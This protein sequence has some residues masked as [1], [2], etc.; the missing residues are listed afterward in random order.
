MSLLSSFVHPVASRKGRFALWLWVAICLITW[1]ATAKY[2]YSWPSMIVTVGCFLAT[3]GAVTLLTR[4]VYFALTLSTTVLLFLTLLSKVKEF[5]WWEKLLFPDFK[6]FLDTSNMGVVLEFPWVF[7]LFLLLVALL[8]VLTVQ[9][10]RYSGKTTGSRWMSLGCTIVGCA[11]VY[12]MYQDYQPT[13]QAKLANRVSN[14]PTNLVMTST[15]HYQDP[16]E[17]MTETSSAFLTA[18]K[19]LTPSALHEAAQKQPLPDIVVLLQ[20]S[21]F[22]PQYYTDIVGDLPPLKMFEPA[23]REQEGLLRV[24]TYGGS[25]WRSEFSVMSGLSSSDFGA[26]AV[27]INYTSVEYVRHG[28]FTELRRYGYETYVLTPFNPRSYNCDV[29]YKAMGV[30][31]IRQPQD[32]GYPAPK[33]KNLWRIPTADM[34]EAVKKLLETEPHD[35][36]RIVFAMTMYEH[37]PYERMMPTDYPVE[38]K[39]G[40]PKQEY[41]NY[42]GKLKAADEPIMAFEAWIRSRDKRHLFIRFGDHQPRLTDH[43]EYSLQAPNPMFVTQFQLID[44]GLPDKGTAYP[45][46]DIVYFPGLILERL[47]GQPSTFFQANMD[48]RRLFNGQYTDALD[49]PVVKSYRA[50]LFKDLA[51]ANKD[52]E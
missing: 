23:N 36:P 28:L 4:R 18:Q 17:L 46:L 32:Y 29:A 35:K 26:N 1:Y 3:T 13:F 42:V 24:H 15:L 27:V 50:Y 52:V 51:A 9:G 49:D 39:A 16:G 44:T 47:K 25:T 2:R 14:V 40:A 31:H 20:E 12:V 43:P 45:L 8:M 19:T 38:L 30:Q 37:S 22:N 5:Y 21:T 11:M 34:L 6:L 10:W 41:A 48:A 33:Y 7:V